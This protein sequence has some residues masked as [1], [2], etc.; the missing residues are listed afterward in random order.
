MTL[1]L[2]ADYVIEFEN[3]HYAA[4][5][6]DDLEN[7]FTALENSLANI[8]QQASFGLHTLSANGTFLS[9]NDKELDWLGYSEQELIGKVKFVDLLTEDSEQKYLKHLA[10]TASSGVDKDIELSFISKNSSVI[11]FVLY[12]NAILNSYGILDRYRSVLFN[13]DARKSMEASLN[14]AETVFETQ[15]G[16][17]I[18]DADCNIIR[19]NK[20]F[21][22]ITGYSA[23]E[24]IGKT[25]SFLSSGQYDPSFYTSM[26]NAIHERNVWEGEIWDKRKNGEIFPARLTI[27]AVKDCKHIVTNYVASL[28]DISESKAATDEIK[29]LAF[30]DSLTL[31][32]NR[33]LLIERLKQALAL[34]R[35]SHKVGAVLFLDLDH[36]KTLNDTFGHNIGDLL[37]KEAAKH[38][39]Q[40]LRETDTVARIG[41]DEFV[42]LLENLADNKLE[43]LAEVGIIGEKILSNLCQGY[44]FDS[45]HHMCT[46]SIGATLF[47][48][49]QMNVEELLKQADIAMYEAKDS[50][51]NSLRFFDPEM[52]KS[53][54]HRAHLD[55]DLR[56]ALKEGQ[57]SLYYQVQVNN[58]GNP[59]GAEALIRWNNSNNEE[60]SPLSFIPLA[61]HTGLII[62]I[63]QWVLDTAC[64]Q[65]SKWQRNKK[66]RKLTLSINVSAIEFKQA[67]FVEQV[68]SA[69]ARH[70]INPAYLTLELTESMLLQDVESMISKMIELR[71]FG[72]RFELD[73]FGTGYSS[74][75]Y[76]KKLPINRLK[77]DKS[78]V[79]ELSTNK[80][81]KKLVHAIINMAHSLDMK[82]IAEGVE[83]QNQLQFLQNSGCDYY[84]G[85]FF[86]KP[87]PV[88]EF[89]AALELRSGLTVLNS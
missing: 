40:S 8:Y 59:L 23:K 10:D 86:G 29:N 28:I 79:R 26:W 11:N 37:L 38:I 69:L 49:H 88:C 73:D 87:I 50:G 80:S 9:I 62:P 2:P 35:N 31:L 48:E 82:V 53:I 54:S 27:K 7:R 64:A 70:D 74:L 33:R 65:I 67:N 20:A 6:Y 13:I 15:D 18:T 39:K 61:E 3:K 71:K 66:T 1:T 21:H 16:M 12:T 5:D 17:M 14:V 84:Q 76:L 36:F 63:G 45:Y 60:I 47:G 57:F 44:E 81:D 58:I 43:A 85:Y 55:H 4:E 77:I 72:V 22:K 30:Y 42:I 83:T 41:G 89:E 56:F 46:A 25:P 78:F 32:P 34:S 68:K 51:R 24:C 52:E 19:V 75:Q